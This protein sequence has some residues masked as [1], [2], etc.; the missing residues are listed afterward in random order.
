MLSQSFIFRK[1][2]LRVEC[3]ERFITVTSLNNAISLLVS[4]IN[5]TTFKS[6]SVRLEYIFVRKTPPNLKMQRQN[7]EM[8][9]GE[10]HGASFELHYRKIKTRNEEFRT[11][12]PPFQINCNYQL[13]RWRFVFFTWSSD[14]VKGTRAQKTRPPSG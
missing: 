4:I 13:K 8:R 11:N 6:I 3:N 5:C 1:G 14:T 7:L 9:K 2:K 12:E 10:I